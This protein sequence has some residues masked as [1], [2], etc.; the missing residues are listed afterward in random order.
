MNR[1]FRWNQNYQR[2]R[3]NQNLLVVRKNQNY[4]NYPK[5]PRTLYFPKP[6][7]DPSRH[8]YQNYQMILKNPYYQTSQ[9]CRKSP[10]FHCFPMTQMNH[11]VQKNQN[12][13]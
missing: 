10:Y 2:N 5:T 9:C 1:N 6:Q 7:E 13:L 11:L 8:L 3:L 4:Q 12:F